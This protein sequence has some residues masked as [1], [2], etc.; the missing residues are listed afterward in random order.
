MRLVAR[1]SVPSARPCAVSAA[2]PAV[3]RCAARRSDGLSRGPRA[4][5]AGRHRCGGGSGAPFLAAR[6]PRRSNVAVCAPVRARG[7]RAGRRAWWRCIAECA[8]A[9]KARESHARAWNHRSAPE[10]SPCPLEAQV[11]GLKISGSLIVGC[12]GSA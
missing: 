10:P 12:N 5:L 3:R 7:Y 6:P 2:S 11:S 8:I 4:T 1:R 9:F